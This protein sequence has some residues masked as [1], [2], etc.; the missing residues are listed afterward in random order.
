M[1]Y[2]T[3]K[4]LAKREHCKVTDLIALAPQ[5]DPFYAGTPNDWALGRWFADLWAK[6]KYGS[7][8]HL[9][10]VHYQ[11]ISQ[12]PPVKMPNGKPYENTETCW[13]TLSAAAKAARYLRLVEPSAFVDRRNPEP[14]IYTYDRG[15][16]PFI[17]VA[18]NLWS[19]ALD[20]PEFP[21]LP[22]YGVE[23]FV[24]EQHYHLEIWCEKS[25]MNDVLIPFCER[26]GINLIT[27]VGEL[28]RDLEN[29]RQAIISRYADRVAELRD[30]YN[31]LRAEFAER[32]AGYS[33][34][35]EA[36]WQAISEEMH[37]APIAIE[38]Y[39]IPEAERG[40]EVGSGLYNSRRDY[41]AQI[42]AYKVFQGKPTPTS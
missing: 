21:E 37:A 38:D 13:D 34:Q 35:I 29:E 6:F 17:T 42:D 11:I 26:Y 27:G 24:G 31:A 41:L 22:R 7:G 10:R 32:A 12:D 33:Q 15:D 1:N 39:P 3:I 9:R 8:V 25:T 4:E 18:D 16:A 19:G 5:N 36:V 23:N 30:G 40:A 14:H 2:E 20:I 28:Q